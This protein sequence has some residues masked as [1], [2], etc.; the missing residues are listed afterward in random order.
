MSATE[1]AYPLS[2]YPPLKNDNS[3]G[4]GEAIQ[5]LAC[6]RA[7]GRLDLN[8]IIPYRIA[9]GHDGFVEEPEQE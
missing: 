9:I 5:G 1:T 4:E 8:L 7:V 6:S 3:F 2:Q